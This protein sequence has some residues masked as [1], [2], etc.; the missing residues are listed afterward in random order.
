[1]VIVK[2]Y[3]VNKCLLSM[4]KAQTIGLN[5]CKLH[6]SFYPMVQVFRLD[7]FFICF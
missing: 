7:V 4:T 5:Q 1:M 2:N 6:Q 3:Y